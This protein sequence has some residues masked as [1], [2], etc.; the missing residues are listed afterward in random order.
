MSH[1]SPVTDFMKL[2]SAALLLALTATTANAAPPTRAQLD[3]SEAK[4]QQAEAMRETDAKA[5]MPLYE[6]AAR[7]GHD[8]DIAFMLGS[9]YQNVDKDADRA[10]QWMQAAAD[11][12]HVDARFE[13]AKM[14]VQG[15][16]TMRDVSGGLQTMEE[17]AR[18]GYAP[19]VGVAKA[20]RTEQDGK[21]QCLVNAL[22]EQGYHET[23]GGRFY[24]IDAGEKETARGDTFV[25]RGF[26]GNSPAW[27]TLRVDGFDGVTVSRSG[28]NVLFS[29]TYNARP[30][31]AEGI[32][33]A[34]ALRS[35]CELDVE[36]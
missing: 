1:R 12:G 5:A 25:V 8:P 35:K 36:S 27:A 6:E 4:F 26:L 7:L 18:A 20:F 13:F 28:S 24:R 32:A 9:I 34:A 29:S 2:L 23:I 21:A 16:G 33:M 22:R 11:W 14:R 3:A 30:A 31:T 17:M 15:A 10:A 19:A